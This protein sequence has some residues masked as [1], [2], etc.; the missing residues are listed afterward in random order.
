M[1]ALWALAVGLALAAAAPARQ[2]DSLG[3]LKKRAET[4][5]ESEQALRYAEVVRQLVESVNDDFAAGRP[6]AAHAAVKDIRLYTDK[7]LEAGRNLPERKLKKVEI[8]LRQAAKRLEDVRRTLAVD[9]RPPIEAAIEHLQDVRTQML[10]RM[11]A[12]DADKA[13]KS[14]KQESKAESKP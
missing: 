6:E 5:R 12:P 4:A 1:R 9:D 8:A 14:E 10:E 13:K 7:S 11:F 3:E 2:Q